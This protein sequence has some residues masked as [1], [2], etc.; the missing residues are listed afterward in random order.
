MGVYDQAQSTR[1]AQR[2]GLEQ[3]GIRLVYLEELPEIAYRGQLIYNGTS[4]Y[5]LVYDG[6]AWQTIGDQSG[7]RLFVQSATPTG[8]GEGDQWYSPTTGL[9]LVFDGASWVEPALPEDSVGAY[10][11]IADSITT[12]ELAANAITTAELAADAITA[13][14]SIVSAA[15]YTALDGPRMTIANDPA[16]GVIRF[17]YGMGEAL[18][19]FINPVQDGSRPKLHLSSGTMAPG[20]GNS[21]QLELFGAFAGG[22]GKKAAFN[23]DLFINGSTAVTSSRRYKEDIQDLTYDRDQILSLRPVEYT[24]KDSGER[25]VGFIAEEAEEAGLHRFV[26]KV[27]GQVEAFNYP[28]YTAALQQVCIEQQADIDHLTARLEALEAR[29]A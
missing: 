29:L 23:C 9:L 2:T 25:N 17:Y 19:G 26:I 14:H 1:L 13:K 24:R 27:D 7:S 4:D 28:A 21:A 6:A 12:N 18:S 22:A 16:G 5:L 20:G 3:P 15:Y 8:A 10:Q 11:I